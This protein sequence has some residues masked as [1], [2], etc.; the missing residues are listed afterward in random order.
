MVGMALDYTNPSADDPLVRNTIQYL[1]NTQLGDGSWNNNN[2]FFSTRLAATSF[3]MAYMLRAL[4]RLGGIDVDLHLSLPDNIQIS[5]LSTPATS[6]TPNSTGG[7]DYFWSLQGVTSNDRVIDFDAT[8]QDMYLGEERP[9]ATNAYMTFDNSFTNEELNVDL[10]VPVVKAA[11]E[12]I[13]GLTTDKV[14]YY[15]DENVLITSIV[16]NT[17]PVIASGTVQ[18]AIHAQGSNEAFAV[19]PAIPVE[20]LAAGAQVSLPAEWNTGLQNEGSHEEVGKLL[21]EHGRLLH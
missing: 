2:S 4:D 9:V 11:S 7:N 17:S 10:D 14:V 3:V 5:N 12:L 20:D 19:L 8:L 6:V 15:A 16:D 1:L 13:L 18:L 21:D